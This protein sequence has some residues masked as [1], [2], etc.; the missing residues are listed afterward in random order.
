MNSTLDRFHTD[1]FTPKRTN[2]E[3][4]S[5]FRQVPADAAAQQQLFLGIENKEPPLLIPSEELHGLRHIER[6]CVRLSDI[7]T[8]DTFGQT[9]NNTRT[10]GT[11]TRDESL[12]GSLEKGIDISKFPPR[13]LKNESG[14]T[15]FGGFGRFEIF[16]ELNYKYWIIDIYEEDVASRTEFQ[17]TTQDVKAHGALADNAFT[18]AKALKKADWLR[19]FQNVIK[20][21][22]ENKGVKLVNNESGIETLNSW[23]KTIP[24]CLTKQQSTDYINDAFL[25]SMQEGVLESVKPDKV[26]RAALDVD[27]NLI[28]LNTADAGNKDGSVGNKQ[29]L[30]RT[31]GAAAKRFVKSGGK[32]QEYVLHNGT[33]TSHEEIDYQNSLTQAMIDEVY[34]DLKKMVLLAEYTGNKQPLKA[35]HVYNQKIGTKGCNTIQSFSEYNWYKKNKGESNG[36]MRFYNG[37]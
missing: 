35:T 37:K 18:A 23:L 32:T 15:L 30:I 6:K 22:E 31:L 7:T 19:A 27:K 16:D 14:L 36:L 4:L 24:N 26:K 12:L 25:S 9:L 8:K 34:E 3:T 10:G 1:I 29:R 33:C 5:T 17:F 21:Y 28:V 11:G 2:M 20:S 13:V